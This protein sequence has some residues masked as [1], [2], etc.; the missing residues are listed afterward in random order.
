M[1]GISRFEEIPLSLDV[2]ELEEE[3]MFLG[4][5]EYQLVGIR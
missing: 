4:S 2:V 1:E 3:C 5:G